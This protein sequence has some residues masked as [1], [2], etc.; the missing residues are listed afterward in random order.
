LLAG[1]LPPLECDEDADEVLEAE[2]EDAEL[3]PPSEEPELDEEWA[4]PEDEPGVLPAP[5][6]SVPFDPRSKE[7][8]P[9]ALKKVPRED[10]PATATGLDTAPPVVRKPDSKNF[11]DL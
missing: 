4:D 8:P 7:R 6:C 10:K 1:L 11:R 3:R 9:P 2:E 5:E